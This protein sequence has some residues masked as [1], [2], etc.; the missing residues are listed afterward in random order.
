MLQKPEEGGSLEYVPRIRGLAD[1]E[2][3][4]ESVLSPE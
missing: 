1:E 3:I 2:T 4:V